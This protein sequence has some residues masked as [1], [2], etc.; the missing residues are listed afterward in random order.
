[1][2][3][4][5]MTISGTPEEVREAV[6]GFAYLYGQSVTVVTT[7]KEAA[8]P[9]ESAA[10]AG[11]RKSLRET[12]KVDP[13]TNR[14]DMIQNGGKAAAPATPAAPTTPVNTV[15]GKTPRQETISQLIA[16]SLKKVEKVKVVELL[17]SFGAKK[18]GEITVADE[19]RFIGAIRVL[20]A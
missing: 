6:L 5:T 3:Q 14:T 19:E 4:M 9:A 11:M 10:K 16:A 2:S 18:G 12:T 13:T 1:M 20:M 8:P 17:A 15:P 7:E